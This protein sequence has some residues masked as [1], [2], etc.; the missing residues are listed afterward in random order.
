[1]KNDNKD[2]IL[3]KEISSLSITKIC[4]ELGINRANIFNGVA[5]DETIKKLKDELTKRLVKIYNDYYN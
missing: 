1:M 3:I 2:L 4:L 5:S